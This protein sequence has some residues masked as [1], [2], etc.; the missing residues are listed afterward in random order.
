MKKAVTLKVRFENLT[1]AQAIALVNM[2]NEM[3]KFGYAGHS[4][5]IGFYADGDGNFHPHVKHNLKISTADLDKYRET[6]LIYERGRR[7]HA[8]VNSNE[9]KFPWT[10][11]IS[12]FDFDGLNIE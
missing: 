11:S 4:A 6:T 12:L 10:D 5:Y 7:T 2:F 9:K 1:K 8:D 3:E